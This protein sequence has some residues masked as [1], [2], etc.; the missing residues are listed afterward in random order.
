MVLLFIFLRCVFLFIRLKNKDTPFKTMDHWLLWKQNK[1]V[2]NVCN[3]V[4]NKLSFWIECLHQLGLWK[5]KVYGAVLFVCLSVSFHLFTLCN[6]KWKWFDFNLEHH[7]CFHLNTWVQYHFVDD[8]KNVPVK[9]AERA[10]NGKTFALFFQ[11]LKCDWKLSHRRFEMFYG[12]KT[13]SNQSIA[14][15]IMK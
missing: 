1:Y 5:T 9:I 4:L 6:R 15:W 3:Y 10:M 7:R 14:N 8:K 11:R 13:P 12:T 2:I